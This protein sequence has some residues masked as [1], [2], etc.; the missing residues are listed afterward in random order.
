MTTFLIDLAGWSGALS[1][2]LAYIL[3]SWRVVAGDSFAYQG[4]NLL[5]GALLAVNSYAHGAFPSV[6]V[7]GFWIVVGV[8]ALWRIWRLRD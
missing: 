7:N 3:V 8:A 4:L 1:L 2:L 5:G 6:V